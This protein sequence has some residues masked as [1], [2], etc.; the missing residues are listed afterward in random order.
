MIYG[1]ETGKKEIE[2]N[3][4]D[5]MDFYDM[6]NLIYP[7]GHTI[8]DSNVERMLAIAYRFEMKAVIE[9]AES[10]L[11]RS[12]D[13]SLP[14]KLKLAVKYRLEGLMAFC[15]TSLKTTSD[16]DEIAESEECKDLS[17]TI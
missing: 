14:S 7:T 5:Y 3:D 6:L 10:L 13:F 4:I 11:I 1:E 8:N 15:F 2:I 9:Q 16:I 12:D 17:E